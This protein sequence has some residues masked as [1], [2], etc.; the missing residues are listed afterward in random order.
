MK[1]IYLLLE[2]K[3]DDVYGED[4]RRQIEKMVQIVAPPL[5]EKTYMSHL[6]ELQQV[7]A[8]FGSW[9]L[10]AFDEEFLKLVP[11]LKVVFYAA[12]TIKFFMTDAAWKR[13]L[14]VCSAWASNAI[15][16]A[17]FNLAHILLANKRVLAKGRETRDQKRFAFPG[18]VAGNYRS[19]VGIVSLGMTGRLLRTYLKPFDH[20]VLVYDPFISSDEAEK[21]NVELVGLPELFRLSDVVSINTPL[22]PE[23]IGL[24]TGQLLDS[25][26]PGATFI[27]TSRGA[28]VDEP[29][30]IDV[31]ARRAD[32]FAVLDVTNPEPPIPESALYSLPN[33]LLTPHLAGSQDTE[34]RRLA[35]AMIEECRRYQAGE[36]LQT[37][38]TQ[39]AAQR[40]A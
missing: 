21:L 22:L 37:Q 15:P 17:E 25:M 39:E 9:G 16:V 32:L 11:N 12:G 7:E 36:P 28:I 35:Q 1:A 14:I 20:R 18:G 26:K 5:N 19:T 27:N 38:V 3:L 23:T 4:E 30:M 24:I 31:L 6:D 13:D 10:P 33:V 29:A 8:I 40:M 2:R 34:C